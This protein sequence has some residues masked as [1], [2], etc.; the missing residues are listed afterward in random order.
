MKGRAPVLNSRRA[1]CDRRM[2]FLT[3]HNEREEARLRLCEL[4][5]SRGEWFC[6]EARGSRGA[7]ASRRA[8]ASRGAITLRAG[9]WE[10]R[11]S[12]GALHF[13][14]W[15]DAG[16]RAWRVA[17][18]E[19][20][21][22]KL[23]LRVT[24][25][26]GAE[27]AV[28]ELVPR[29]S[30]REG[31]AAVAAARLAACERL[32]A[33]VSAH[34]PGSVVESV[35]LSAGARRSEPGR[36]A[37]VLLGRGRGALIAA[38]GA[39]VD[40][41]AHEVDSML[42]SA[43]RW[44]SR[45]GESRRARKTAGSLKLWLVAPR[46]LSKATAERV[47][48]LRGE[49]RAAIK[50]FE[51]GDAMNFG[52]AAEITAPTNGRGEAAP[53]AEADAT[54][55]RDGVDEVNGAVDPDRSARAAGLI[56]IEVPR[57]ESLLGC[58]PPFRFARRDGLSDTAARLV[59]L[60]PESVDV[61]KSRHGETI[62]FR[63]LPFARVRRLLGEERVWFGVPGAGAKVSLEEGN[64]RLLAKLLDD[65]AAHR[66]ADA[67]DKR[68]ALYRAAPEAWLESLLRRDVTRLDPGLVVSPLHVQL[69]TSRE[70]AGAGSRPV[71]LLAL[72]RDGR[73]V[74][75]ELKVSE[76]AALPLQGADYWRRVAAHHRAGH[77]RAARLFGD[78]E[79]SD[80]APLVYLVAPALRFHSSFRTLARCVAPEVEM[81]RFDL[82]ED[83]RAGVRV[84]RR[85]K[86]NND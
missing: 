66:R 46:G 15:A 31:A 35:R 21:G 51:S 9:E 65:L 71:D 36:Y 7:E 81:Y 57:L 61:T 56:E 38:T 60:A 28:L 16:S 1:A 10:L 40:I 13:S 3:T 44:W 39:V 62:R 58:A 79:I 25:A 18:W 80:D 32:A 29:A 43:L 6:A 30:A 24:R 45:A 41:R 84:A 68:H 4:L 52:G 76:D 8:D 23:S 34:A 64:W 77:V 55:T 74:V 14:Y 78:A 5:E 72:R 2:K 54:K 42:A 26:A 27:R 75:V 50:L 69:R 12:G 63:G 53:E 37:R 73:L 11:G 19:W 48:L 82:N 86:V 22:G 49:V 70:A 67:E 47:S 83:W 17:A 85:T 59:A 20:A 33:L